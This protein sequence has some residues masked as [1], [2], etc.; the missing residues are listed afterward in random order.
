M[1]HPTS[2]SVRTHPKLHESSQVRTPEQSCVA[3]LKRNTDT[4]CLRRE[5]IVYVGFLVSGSEQFR[6]KQNESNP[7]GVRGET[8]SAALHIVTASANAFHATS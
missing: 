1:T 6:P 8:P 7:D 5:S 3:Q 2:E 4:S